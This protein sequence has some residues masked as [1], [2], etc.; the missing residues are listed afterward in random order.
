MSQQEIENLLKDRRRRTEKEICEELKITLGPVNRA[1]RKMY[2]RHELKMEKKEKMIN[3]KSN[4]PRV[5]IIRVW[6]K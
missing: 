1:L 4:I 5:R 2:E 6:F 3:G